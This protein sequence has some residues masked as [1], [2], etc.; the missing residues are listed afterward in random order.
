[1]SNF[2]NIEAKYWKKQ[3]YQD[4]IIE[5]EI[6]EYWYNF[7]NVIENGKSIGFRKPALEMLKIV[8]KK[9][10]KCRNVDCKEKAILVDGLNY[11]RWKCPKCNTDAGA[12]HRYKS[13]GS[14]VPYTFSLDNKIAGLNH[15]RKLALETRTW[16]YE[17]AISKSEFRNSPIYPERLNLTTTEEKWA[18]MFNY[19]LA[20]D[21]DA[22]KSLKGGRHN[23]FG[24]KKPKMLENGQNLIDLS[25]EY[26]IDELGL[27]NDN[28]EWHF[29]GN[30]LYLILKKEIVDEQFKLKQESNYE[31]FDKACIGWNVETGKINDI[32][33]KN[34]IKFMD[35]DMQTK[36]LRTY[37]KSPFSLH[38]TFD[39][40]C[41][42]LTAYFGN[43]ESINLNNESWIEMTYPK[44]ITNDFINEMKKKIDI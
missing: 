5:N 33:K 6:D 41:F 3:D 2:K 13:F 32:L 14:Y 36:S 35:A 1:M 7:Y 8:A 18:M 39:R 11:A 20:I 25:N 9:K 17:Q 28:F 22:K 40:I 31:F 16:Y 27:S 43:N 4:F 42:P 29:S 19:N 26:I 15:I 21:F 10:H 38:L 23:F 37:I 24:D 44:N 34:K 30:G 12:P